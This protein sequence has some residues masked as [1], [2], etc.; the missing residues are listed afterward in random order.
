[1]QIKPQEDIE[2][3]GSG[4]AVVRTSR[5]RGIRVT[6]ESPDL[7]PMTTD[8]EPSPQLFPLSPWRAYFGCSSVQCVAV[9]NDIGCDAQP[10]SSVASNQADLRA[11]II[12]RRHYDAMLSSLNLPHRS[13]LGLAFDLILGIPCVLLLWGIDALRVFPGRIASVFDRTA[14]V[15]R[16]EKR[17]KK[18]EASE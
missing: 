3:Q 12:R 15:N 11:S 13:R 7:P 6:K 5:S 14:V 2:L 8:P 10:P 4:S 1:M 17:R 16:H 18:H 9:F